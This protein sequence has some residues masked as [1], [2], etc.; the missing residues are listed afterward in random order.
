M[1]ISCTSTFD[2]P[3]R[4]VFHLDLFH[5]RRLNPVAER[6]TPQ[7]SLKVNYI[8]NHMTY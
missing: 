8:I 6:E 4:G 2:V 5:I 1:I 3:G 7:S